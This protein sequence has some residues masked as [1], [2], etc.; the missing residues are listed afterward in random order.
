M[1]IFYSRF[2]GKQHQ[3]VEGK[4]APAPV[5]GRAPSPRLLSLG[6]ALAAPGTRLTQHPDPLQAPQQSWVH[7]HVK[8]QQPTP[9]AHAWQLRSSEIQQCLPHTCLGQ[10]QWHCQWWARKKTHSLTCLQQVPARGITAE[11]GNCCPTKEVLIYTAYALSAAG[12][13]VIIIVAIVVVVIIISVRGRSREAP[14]DPHGRS[15][16]PALPGDVMGMKEMVHPHC[17]VLEPGPYSKPCTIPWVWVP[18]G[19]KTKSFMPSP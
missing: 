3:E 11:R 13:A 4:A 5:T 7:R 1:P 6:D 16:M 14:L 12:A 10:G 2:G 19:A 8:G 9:P 17:W 15:H 18:E